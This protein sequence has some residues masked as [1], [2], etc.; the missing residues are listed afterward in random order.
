MVCKAQEPPSPQAAPAVATLVAM[1]DGDHLGPEHMPPWFHERVEQVLA[2]PA[3][4]PETIIAIGELVMAM[5]RWDA[6]HVPA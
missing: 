1:I 6:R 4:P 2:D 3:T 5:D